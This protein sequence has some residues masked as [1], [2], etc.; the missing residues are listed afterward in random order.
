MTFYTSK[1]LA[2]SKSL[3]LESK[4]LICLKKLK[5]DPYIKCTWYNYQLKLLAVTFNSKILINRFEFAIM[6]D[7]HC[8]IR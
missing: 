6:V 2:E 8:S 4:S 1:K 5:Q 3:K 7:R